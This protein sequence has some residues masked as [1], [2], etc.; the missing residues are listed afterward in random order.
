[1]HW[2]IGLVVWACQLIACTS[3][4][5]GTESETG[6]SET[7]TSES[8]ES[9]ESTGD[10]TAASEMCEAGVATPDGCFMQQDCASQPPC[11]SVAC[12]SLCAQ[13]Y[14]GDRAECWAGCDAE[15]EAANTC[16]RA[17]ALTW[18]ECSQLAPCDLVALDACTAEYSACAQAC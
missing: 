18:G 15:L 3:S 11:E 4:D 13:T 6:E 10:C 9:S 8:S 12:Q 16:R 1:M 5:D 14:Y 7:A 2:R 17:C